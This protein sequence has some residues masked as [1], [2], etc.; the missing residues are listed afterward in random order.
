MEEK[1]KRKKRRSIGESVRVITTTQT[2]FPV[3][4][5]DMSLAAATAGISSE[6]IKYITEKHFP[7]YKDYLIPRLALATFLGGSTTMLRYK[8]ADVLNT[9]KT[10][11]K[12]EDK[13][14]GSKTTG[15]S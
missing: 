14:Y 3:S 12:S 5:L 10:K 6:V 15:N 9:L 2:K 4:P 11:K 13:T 1:K 7:K 8:I